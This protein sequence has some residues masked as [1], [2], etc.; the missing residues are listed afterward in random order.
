MNV[1][2]NNYV[3]FNCSSLLQNNRD[4]CAVDEQDVLVF[5]M[6]GRRNIQGLGG[7]LLARE[8]LDKKGHLKNVASSNAKPQGW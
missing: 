2:D 5:S 1:I 4:F 3:S 6:Q 8:L 7:D